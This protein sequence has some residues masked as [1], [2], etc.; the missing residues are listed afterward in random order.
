MLN[1]EEIYD[2]VTGLAPVVRNEIWSGPPNTVGN[3]DYKV[4]LELCSGG[5]GYR[6][7]VTLK[8]PQLVVKGDAVPSL[9]VLSRR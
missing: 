2:A 3:Q 7:Q 6:E 8:P 1:A 5:C 4:V 9:I